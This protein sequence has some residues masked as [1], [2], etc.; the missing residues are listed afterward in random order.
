MNYTIIGNDGKTYGPADAEQ[1]RQW[2]AQ[3]RV[4]SR[5]PI[6]VAGTADW[7]FV[8]LLPEFAP[9]FSE[10]PPVIAAAKP[11]A[12]QPSKNNQLAVWGLVCGILAWTFCCCCIPFN[13]L[14]LVLSIIALVQI[15]AHPGTQDGRGL[16]IAGIALSATN[17]F[18]CGGLTLF[19]LATSAPNIH[20][21][22]GQN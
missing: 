10:T 20:F 6:F 14:G 13:L 3:K 22:L 11:G 12:T 15:N 1:I 2:I 21:N 9:Q 19:N 4:E 17:L 8:G 7:T 16:A 5:T 18:W